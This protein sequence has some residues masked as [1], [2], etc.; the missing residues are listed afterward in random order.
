M[1]FNFIISW[2]KNIVPIR[3]S[4]VEILGSGK[5]KTSVGPCLFIYFWFNF[6]IFLDPTISTSIRASWFPL[7]FNWSLA[8]E[9]IFVL[10][11]FCLVRLKIIILAIQIFLNDSCYLRTISLLS[12]PTHHFSHYY[13]KL[14]LSRIYYFFNNLFYLFLIKLLREI[15]F[16]N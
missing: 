15:F 7:F 11:S 6:S 9:I 5:D 3:L 8:I 2:H 1:L 10:F 13:P 16:N 12:D 14:F 4:V